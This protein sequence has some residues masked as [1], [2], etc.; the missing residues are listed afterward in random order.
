MSHVV[1][2]TTQVRDPV[3]V[4]AACRRLG[5]AEPVEGT[6]RLYAGEATGL[7][8]QLPEWRYPIVIDIAEGKLQL[9]NYSGYW[10][11]Q[12]QLDRFLQAYAV[13]K[14]RLTARAQGH[15]VSEQ[16]LADGAIK[17]TITEG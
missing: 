8:V 15:T 6:A 14:A 16:T 7:I 5:L 9:D 13:E 1:T 4:A 2:I 11:A 17:L 12:A 10:G 3:A